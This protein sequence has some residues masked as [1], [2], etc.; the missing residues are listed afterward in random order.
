MVRNFKSVLVKK[1]YPFSLRCGLY[2]GCHQLSERSFH[3]GIRQF[4]LCARCTG[5]YL[6][7]AIGLIISTIYL[8]SLLFS[9]II[10]LPMLIDG[11][12][13]L[14]TPYESNNLRRLGTGLLFGYAASSII[15][16][17]AEGIL[18]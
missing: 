7:L 5:I 12:T 18:V 3:I 16:I 15:V 14:L 17:V 9:I 1:V 13:Q 8:P 6:A 4:P 10:M 2:L 11:F